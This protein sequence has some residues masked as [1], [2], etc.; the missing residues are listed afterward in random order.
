MLLQGAFSDPF[1]DRERVTLSNPGN[2]YPHNSW[3][4]KDW[5][6][7]AAA[8]IYAQAENCGLVPDLRLLQDELNAYTVIGLW[9]YAVP[10][11]EVQGEWFQFVK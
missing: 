10:F 11:P 7:A 8:A 1:F 9:L 6:I 4:Y 3:S 2:L 5:F